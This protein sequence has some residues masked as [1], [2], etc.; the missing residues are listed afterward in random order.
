MLKIIQ[1]QYKLLKRKIHIYMYIFINEM[2]HV[3][4]YFMLSHMQNL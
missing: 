2:N 3:I 4:N 1:E